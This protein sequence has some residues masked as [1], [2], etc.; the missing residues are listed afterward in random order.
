[1]VKG[2][3]IFSLVKGEGNIIRLVRV[4]TNLESVNELA[5]FK[6]SIAFLLKVLKGQFLV[7]L[8]NSLFLMDEEGAHE[9][10]LKTNR[11][12][13]FF[14]HATECEKYTFIQE[15]G[16]PPTGIYISEDL[17]NWKK[18]ITNVELDKRSKHFHCIA[19]DPYRKF[20]IVTLGDA[21]LT[22]VVYS[23]DLGWSWK[24]LYKGAWQFVPIVPLKD[25]LVLGMDSG[26][27]KGG[28][29]IY[30][31]SRAYWDFI[32]FRRHDKNVRFIQMCDLVHLNDKFWVASLGTP[33]ALIISRNLRD[34]HMIHLLGEKEAFNPHMRLSEGN[35][36]LAC[37]TGTSLLVIEKRELCGFK[38]T[39]P[40]VKQYNAYLDRIKGYGFTLKRKFLELPILK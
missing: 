19:W 12:E 35:D 16:H 36:F 15:Y 2:R 30:Y 1:M 33:Q 20:L 6:G 22:R 40:V 23:E 3:K 21:C 9:T 37:S 38:E 5:S 4:E 39:Q 29:G 24:P 27:A 28:I 17:E 25:K 18:I 10:V 26:I 11:A 32:F 13:N 7:S 14:W 31:P 34:W 8:D